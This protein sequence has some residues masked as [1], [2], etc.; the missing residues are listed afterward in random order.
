MSV[1]THG[2]H[3]GTC[4]KAAGWRIRRHNEV[5]DVLYQLAVEAGHTPGQNIGK[6]K[7]ERMSAMRPA[8]IWATTA[9]MSPEERDKYDSD[10]DVLMR[11]GSGAARGGRGT[12]G[13]DTDFI[14]TA[15]DVTITETQQRN[16]LRPNANVKAGAMAHDAY[17]AKLGKYRLL[18]EKLR[19]LGVR[20][21]RFQPLAFESSGYV[22][23]VARQRIK[24]W[25]AEAKL[26]LGPERFAFI[27]SSTRRKITTIIHFWGAVA[28][29]G[30]L[31][32]R[33][34]LGERGRQP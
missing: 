25:E 27:G 2:D 9:R 20:N 22:H 29:C 12:P 8:D 23:P 11:D 5:R 6:E 26:R 34:W 30:A 3:A 21:R 18:F 13:R 28:P 10:G 4:L 1:D 24:D 32:P 19:D 14:E 17:E 7:P 16:S 15:Y 31:R 33:D